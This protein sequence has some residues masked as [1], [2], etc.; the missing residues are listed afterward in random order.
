MKLTP[1]TFQSVHDI[2]K[3]YCYSLL[4]YFTKDNMDKAW[5]LRNE[6]Y[7]YRPIP[8]IHTVHELHRPWLH[9]RRLLTCLRLTW[10]KNW[11]WDYQSYPFTYSRSYLHLLKKLS[12]FYLRRIEF[13][14]LTPNNPVTSCLHS[15]EELVSRAR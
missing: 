11:I 3:L 10:L 4:L 15:N 13:L 6:V 12:C 5:A 7:I 1:L 2:L 8:C 14:T 9:T